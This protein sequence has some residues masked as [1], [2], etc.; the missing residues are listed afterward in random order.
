MNR[1]RHIVINFLTRH[2]LKAV[3]EEEVLLISGRDWLLNKRKLSKEEVLMLKEEAASLQDSLLWKLAK[4]ELK[5]GAT[6]QRLDKAKTIEDM[7]FG[8]AQ[9]YNMSLL[10]LFFE[11][12]RKL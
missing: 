12:I 1:L 9:M 4:K 3:T 6:Q 8:K 2:L 11:R 5:Y 10:E 7:V